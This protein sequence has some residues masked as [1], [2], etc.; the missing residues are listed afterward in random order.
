LI[1]RVVGA[2]WIKGALLSLIIKRPLTQAQVNVT[3]MAEDKEMES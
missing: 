1:S 3:A 2:K